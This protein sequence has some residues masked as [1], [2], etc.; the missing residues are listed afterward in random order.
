[1]VN[2]YISL[3]REI[4]GL[5][6]A[7]FVAGI[8]EGV[9]DGAGFQVEGVSAHSVGVDGAEAGEGGKGKMT[10]SPLASSA[11]RGGG[12]IEGLR[13]LVGLGGSEVRG[14]ENILAIQGPN[15]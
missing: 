6:C 8:I 7:A 11:G 3:P 9:C 4:N 15:G 14:R 1:M 10:L 13:G 5:N 12:L 2:T